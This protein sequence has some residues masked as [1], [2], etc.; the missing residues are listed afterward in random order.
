MMAED[1]FSIPDVP[2]KRI[3][4]SGKASS[5]ASGSEPPIFS[6]TSNT[7]SHPTVGTDSTESPTP[8]VGDDIP[9][10]Q[11]ISVT[12]TK[13][14][15]TAIKSVIQRYTPNARILE[16]LETFR[17][18]V[19]DC[20]RI[21]LARQISSFK[22]LSSLS[23]RDLSGYNCPAYYKKCAISGASGILASRKK[24]IK[25]GFK[26][27]SPYAVK[28]QLVSCYGFKLENGV[29]KLPIGRREYFE[30][31]L[32]RH[33]REVLAE[34]GLA[35]RSFTLTASTV[36]LAISKR[37][38]L[39]EC[40]STAGLDRNLREFT[41]GNDTRVVKYN[42]SKAV[43]I[44]DTTRKIVSSFKRNDARIRRR[45]ASKYG[46]RRKNRIG[47]LL[48]CV[49]K[50][51]VKRAYEDKEAIVLED[52]EGIRKLYRRGNGQSRKYRDRM[53]SWSFFEA[54]RQ[55][56][57]KASWKGVTVIHLT[58]AETRG[59]TT[60]CAKCGER[61]QSPAR[62][63]VKHRR[64]LWCPRCKRWVDRDVNAVINQAARGR[65]RFD[66]SL[67]QREAKGEAV[68]AIRQVI[69]EPGRQEMPV[70]LRVDASKLIHG[71]GLCI[72]RT[73]ATLP[74][75]EQSK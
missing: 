30:I 45:N 47:H 3:G 38:P 37:V 57:Y 33:T 41:Y 25:R 49:T 34:A 46:M 2:K 8:N 7:G 44:A 16:L 10:P 54:Q 53:N 26:T 61:L 21:G 70:I 63:D 67:L 56:E 28:L 13:D 68:E 48:N 55:V 65:L 74:S 20:I 9:R 1:I 17:K 52:I 72:D 36:S 71:N 23:Y 62:D 24:S 75:Q 60:D 19:N 42:L 66:R 22:K 69:E 29:F 51:I 40:T 18:M 5:P 11:S 73:G 59:T 4:I 6:A 32:N 12:D 39:I 43:R 58:K 50:D 14:V 15:P 27:K 64:M 31:P 35:V